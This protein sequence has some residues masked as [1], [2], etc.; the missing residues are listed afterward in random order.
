MNR[1]HMVKVKLHN[2]INDTTCSTNF[3]KFQINFMLLHTICYCF[4]VYVL[5]KVMQIAISTIAGD[6]LS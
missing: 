3:S 5:T 4:S 6:L 1:V 2:S